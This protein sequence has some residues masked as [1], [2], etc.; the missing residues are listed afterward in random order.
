MKGEQRGRS[1]GMSDTIQSALVVILL[2]MFWHL[3]SIVF[4]NSIVP[5]FQ[6]PE[7]LFSV[8][9]PEMYLIYFL[10]KLAES[11]YNSLKVMFEIFY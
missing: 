2:L 8:T 3:C 9:V 6:S 5:L 7:T 1:S 4:Y 11:L 10:Q